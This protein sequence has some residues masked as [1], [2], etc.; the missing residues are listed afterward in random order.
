M[1]MG[2]VL[3]LFLQEELKPGLVGEYHHT[4]ERIQD[5]PVLEPGAKPRFKR[6]DK[7]ID[8]DRTVGPFHG[9]K[10]VDDFYVR[11][12]G[13]VRVPK[14][15]KWKFLTVS[16][17]GSRLLLDRRKVVDNGGTH[18]MRE[19]AGEVDLEAGDHEI[20]VEYFDR[21]AHAGIRV[22]W[23]GPGQNKDVIGAHALFHKPAAEPTEEEKKG[24]E[25]PI[26][27]PP[28]KDEKP[29]PGQT[30]EK[31]KDEPRREP[32]KNGGPYDEKIVGKG[33]AQP[34]FTGRV[35]SVFQDGPTTLVTV[36]RAGEERP[37][38]VTRETKVVYLE[39]SNKSEER[40]TAGFGAYIWLKPGTSDAAATVK[41]T[42]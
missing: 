13:I 18:E 23:E 28:R 8:F 40:P 22:L 35:T 33:D 16:D 36:R 30:A 34:D 42:K 17:D 15:G 41:F 32:E 7:R 37:I 12:T 11:W 26:D 9:T 14:P 25:L 5:F 3:A 10:L 38:F 27:L 21:Y 20:L 29:P 19:A 31:P 39:F 4:G 2:F 24:I 1:V 6:V